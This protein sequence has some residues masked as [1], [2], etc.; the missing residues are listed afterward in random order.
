MEV[1]DSQVH[2]T[3]PSDGLDDG[4]AQRPGVQHVSGPEMREAMDEAGVDAGLIVTSVAGWDNS[5]P[6][7]VAHRTPE[8]FRVVGRVDH[9]LPDVEDRIERF[10]ADPAAIGLRVVIGDDVMAEHARSDGFDAYFRAAVR[11]A[12][13]VCI[14]GARYLDAVVALIERHDTTQFVLDHFGVGGVVLGYTTWDDLHLDAR[15]PQVL[16]LAARDNVAVKLSGGPSLS[17]ESAPFLD[18][19]P[20]VDR[21]LDAFGP[22][23]LMWGSD[24]TR[25]HNASYRE[26]VDW[27]RESGRLAPDVADAVFGGSLRRVFAWS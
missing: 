6:L 23:R 22:D 5:Y 19:W 14:I 15:V 10:A 7:E 11:C 17:H 9:T 16:G 20:L 13:P 3:R 1:V 8:R 21:Y 4:V 12:L 18:L 26:G 2:V 27:V 25:V 24:W